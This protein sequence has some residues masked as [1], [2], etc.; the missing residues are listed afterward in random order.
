MG[1]KR[2]RKGSAP[3]SPDRRH[4]PLSS[5]FLRARSHHFFLVP[6]SCIR[7]LH[8]ADS[9]RFSTSARGRRYRCMKIRDAHC[10]ELGSGSNLLNPCIT[11]RYP[12]R[13][14]NIVRSRRWES[15]LLPLGCLD[16]VKSRKGATMHC[17]QSNRTKEAPNADCVRVPV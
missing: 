12:L 2:R 11:V 6:R 17:Q 15:F 3:P 1:E 8:D 10:S 4:V 16:A 7:R 9:S 14:E 13:L 5:V